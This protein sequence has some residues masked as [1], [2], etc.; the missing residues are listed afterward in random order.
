M[1]SLTYLKTIFWP[2]VQ[3]ATLPERHAALIIASDFSPSKG[4]GRRGHA[5]LV[6]MREQFDG[7][8]RRGLYPLAPRCFVCASK[9][10]L[11]RHHIIMLVNLGKNHNLNIVTLCRYCHARIHPWLQNISGL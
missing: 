8:V 7:R 10:S 6:K 2:K 9:E 1:K 11:V 5:K 4:N 3:G